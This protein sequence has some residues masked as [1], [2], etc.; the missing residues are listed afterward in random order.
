MRASRHPVQVR[1]R[2]GD[3]K[4]SCP[5]RTVTFRECEYLYQLSPT[6]T[7]KWITVP[8]TLMFRCTSHE[9]RLHRFHNSCTWCR[10]ILIF[11]QQEPALCKF[12]NCL[13]LEPRASAN[14]P[15]YNPSTYTFYHCEERKGYLNLNSN[16]HQLQ[17][18][19]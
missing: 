13:D 16:Q 7:F 10:D 11:T 19:R 18:V 1:N 14:R 8:R 2:G 12:F 9:S 6:F 3:S 17:H 5:F 15:C 4:C